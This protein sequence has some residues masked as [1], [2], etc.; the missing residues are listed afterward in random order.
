M[1][2]GKY[3]NFQKSL[4]HIKVGQILIVNFPV[5]ILRCTF[6]INQILDS[7]EAYSLNTLDK[8][9]YLQSY[10]GKSSTLTP[11]YLTLSLQPSKN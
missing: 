5:R 10:E 4:K 1:D 7:D 2:K 11:F 9:Y 8:F 3:R 6:K